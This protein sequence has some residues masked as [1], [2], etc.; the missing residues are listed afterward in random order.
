MYSL[1]I[2]NATIVNE[3]GLFLG[4]INIVDGII[5]KIYSANDSPKLN[6]DKVIDAEGKYLFPGIIDDQVHFRE[7]GL[8]HKAEIY[9]E[10]KAAVAGGITSFMEMPNTKPQ[11]T[12]IE[13]LEEKYKIASKKSLANYSFY[14]GATNENI[15]EIKKL[16]PK[17]ICGLKVFMGSSTGNML[18]DDEK[19]LS[20][21]FRDSPV[22][23]ATHCEDE[24]TIIENTEKYKKEF[25]EDLPIKYHPLIRSEEA[26]YISSSFAVEL[27]KKYNSRLHILHLSTA[28]ELELFDNSISSKD[29]RITAE[30]CVHHLWFSEEDY[31][32][33]GTR[34][35]WNPAIKKKSDR[36]ALLE[37]L[38]NNKIDVI[39]TDHA[40]HTF[41]EKDNSY[42]KAPSGGPLVQHSLVA[43]LELYHQNKISLIEIVNKM[44]HTPADIFQVAK[45]GYIKEG[46]FADLVLVDLNDPWTVTDENS[47]YKCKW[48][49][50]SGQSF[51][52]K[53][54][55]TIING[56]IVYENGVFNETIKGQRLVFDR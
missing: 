10:S 9:T 53:I 22:L 25:G 23:I 21:I 24:K 45:R 44:C 35:K 20:Q 7:P 47:L 50:F 17:A 5:N 39:A 11:A 3:E 30:V 4:N 52:S 2:K 29:K 12:T 16:N 46:Y 34:I 33:Y 28:K 36:D 54:T 31:D 26:C 32:K 8:T 13:V 18:V 49:P 27:A 41:E 1:Y 56:N 6:P 40:P 19:A 42:F 38:K 48:S 55:H 15:D 43:M 51:R 37:G 14:L